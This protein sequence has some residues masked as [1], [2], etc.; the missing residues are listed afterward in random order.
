MGSIQ[1]GIG[2]ISGIDTSGLINALI[3]IQRQQVTRLEDRIK[4]F[5]QT[6]AGVSTLEANVLAIKTSVQ[7]LGLDSTF[8]SFTVKNSD[9]TQLTATATAKAIAGSYEFQVIRK[10]STHTI[11]SRGF[12]NADQQALGTTGTL[13]IQ[14][15]GE[16]RAAHAA[17]HAQ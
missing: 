11:Q 12:A 2:L 4:G 16:A 5:Q 6:Q 10:A 1:S 14:T 3:S 17:R 13:T 8:N 9:S 7:A 15:G